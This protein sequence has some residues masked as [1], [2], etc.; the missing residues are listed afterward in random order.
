MSKKGAVAVG[1]DEKKDQA[2]KILA[3]GFG[4]IGEKII[5]IGKE[6]DVMIREDALLF[7]SLSRL[8]IGENIPV[9]LYQVVAELLAYVYKVEK[10][11]K[12]KIV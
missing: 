2:P 10:K 1:Y 5:E 3:K 8:E 6:H 11:Y 7:E 12:R 9:K 4:K